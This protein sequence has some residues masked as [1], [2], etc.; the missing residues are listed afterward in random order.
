M[1]EEIQKAKCNN[2]GN[3]LD[4]P[5][6]IPFEKRKPCT[7]CGSL[8][9]AFQINVSDTMQVHDQHDQIRLRHKNSDGKK[10]ADIISG[11][12]FHRDSGNWRILERV[13]DWG[14]NWYKELIT[15][16]VTG[17]II[18]FTDEPLD[19]HTGHGSAKK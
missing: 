6:N 2:C 13:I 17:E 9:R 16:L 15:D 11:D 3:Q 7:Q 4:E 18:K 8:N 12:D 19:Q 1:T 10:L 5:Y 14:K